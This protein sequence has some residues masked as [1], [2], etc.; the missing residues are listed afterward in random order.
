MLSN[1]SF[2]NLSFVIFGFFLL[3]SKNEKG[4]KV[5]WLLFYQYMSPKQKW[6]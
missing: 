4:G 3:K 5:K 6:T 2:Y 1:T